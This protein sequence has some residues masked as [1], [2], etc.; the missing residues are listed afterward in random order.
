MEDPKSE[1]VK[2]PMFS[3]A[4]E[5]SAGLIFGEYVAIGGERRHHARIAMQCADFREVPR[6]HRRADKA[7]GEKTLHCRIASP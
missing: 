2:A 3:G 5:K 7:R 6:L 1:V 4:L